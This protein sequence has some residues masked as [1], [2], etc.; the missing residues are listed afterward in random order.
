MN[1]IQYLEKI[2]RKY[3]QKIQTA[4]S[5]LRILVGIASVSIIISIYSIVTLQPV[6]YFWTSFAVAMLSVTLIICQLLRINYWLNQI[7][8]LA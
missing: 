7:R 6:I 8:R 3:V 5:V 2:Q 1:A 4:L